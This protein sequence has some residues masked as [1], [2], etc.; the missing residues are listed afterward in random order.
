[1]RLLFGF[2]RFISIT[3]TKFRF[4]AVGSRSQTPSFNDI[5]ASETDLNA[6]WS[7]EMLID[8]DEGD[9]DMFND[10]MVRYNTII[11]INLIY[12][13]ILYNVM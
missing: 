8:D 6:S 11:Y 10:S 4:L 2:C 13:N 7:A 12:N 1:M 9:D 5:Q 3:R